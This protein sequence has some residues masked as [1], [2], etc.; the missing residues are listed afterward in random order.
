MNKKISNKIIAILIIAIFSSSIP[1]VSSGPE[2]E[3]KADLMPYDIERTTPF[4]NKDATFRL[5]VYNNGNKTAF[6]PWNDKLV[7]DE[8]T[9]EEATMG[10]PEWTVDLPALTMDDYDWDWRAK[11]GW[12]TVTVYVDWYNDTDEWNESNNK[13]TEQFWWL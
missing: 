4:W 8:G 13:L 9:Q 7:W 11:S 3:K 10:Y 6:S 2:P 12:H 5:Y 1:L